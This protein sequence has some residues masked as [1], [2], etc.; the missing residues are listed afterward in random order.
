MLASSGFAYAFGRQQGGLQVLEEF[1]IRFEASAPIKATDEA[2][3][4]DPHRDAKP[5]R[6]RLGAAAVPDN[7]RHHDAPD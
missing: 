6:F 3:D 7:R 5:G 1:E 2:E 4:D